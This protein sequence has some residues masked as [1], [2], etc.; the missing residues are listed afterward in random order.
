MSEVEVCQNF[1]LLVKTNFSI[2][3][4]EQRVK[5]ANEYPVKLMLRQTS[6]SDISLRGTKE[7]FFDE[8]ESPLNALQYIQFDSMI[9][10]NLKYTI[11]SN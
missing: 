7:K 8:N 11:F 4:N 2:N 3:K 9:D 10:A 6:T 5:V 1:Q